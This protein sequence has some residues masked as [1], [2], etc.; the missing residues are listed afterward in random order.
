MVYQGFVVEV[1]SAFKIYKMF[2]LV[3]IKL[4]KIQGQACHKETK[5]EK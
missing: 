3:K 1:V 5:R 2:T 4:G